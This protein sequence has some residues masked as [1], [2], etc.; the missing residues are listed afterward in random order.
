[1][2]R[3]PLTILIENISTPKEARSCLT[4]D[5]DGCPLLPEINEDKITIEG[6]R[7]A[8]TDYVEAH[9]GMLVLYVAF[10]I[11]TEVFLPT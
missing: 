2:T 1:M 9:W 7:K 11:L 4:Y 6:F 10:L 3:M 5:E 8:L